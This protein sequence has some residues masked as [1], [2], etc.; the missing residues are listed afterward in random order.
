MPGLTGQRGSRR[1]RICSY[2][3]AG[4]RFR[5][6]RLPS[7]P[8]ALSGLAGRGHHHDRPTRPARGCAPRSRRRGGR[9]R[10]RAPRA[11]MRARGN[12]SGARTR[13]RH[14]SNAHPAR[15]MSGGAQRNPTNDAGGRRCEV[16]EAGGRLGEVW[17]S[18]HSWHPLARR[19][20][21]RLGLPDLRSLTTPSLVVTSSFVGCRAAGIS[22]TDAGLVADRWAPPCSSRSA[23][24]DGVEPVGH[25]AVQCSPTERPADHVGD[26]E[27]GSIGDRLTSTPDT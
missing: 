20:W 9:S 12:G 6:G 17:P 16:D 21:D 15:T 8:L 27:G 2:N 26:G 19:C 10:A 23:P 11:R 5:A 25:S 22:M 1:A 13:D 24:Q 7:F 18:A 4:W 14:K 3:R